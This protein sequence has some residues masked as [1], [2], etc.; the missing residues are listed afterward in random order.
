M[1]PLIA[2]LKIAPHLRPVRRL[3]RRKCPDSFKVT[4]LA[5]EENT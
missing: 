2:D 5:A 1:I 4:Q 3:L